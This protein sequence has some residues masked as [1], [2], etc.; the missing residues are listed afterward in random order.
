MSFLKKNDKILV[1][2]TRLKEKYQRII[3]LNIIQNLKEEL[4]SNFKYQLTI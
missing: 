2:N 3:K 1:S 4:D